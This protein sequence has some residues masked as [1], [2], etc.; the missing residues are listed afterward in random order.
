MSI[1][2]FPTQVALVDN[3]LTNQAWIVVVSPRTGKR[4]AIP[5]N[6]PRQGLAVV[7]KA[8]EALQDFG[9]TTVQ[10]TSRELQ[11]FY[12]AWRA[13][14]NMDDRACEEVGYG[15]EDARIS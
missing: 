8:R 6:W 7:F 11:Q 14:K 12:G 13:Y 10:L 4:L 2:T 15:E 3:K 5:C 9:D 1:K